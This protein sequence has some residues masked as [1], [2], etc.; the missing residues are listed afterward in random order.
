MVI[1]QYKLDHDGIGAMLA[2]IWESNCQQAVH[3][4]CAYSSFLLMSALADLSKFSVSEPVFTQ[5]ALTLT[6][7]LTLGTMT[8]TTQ[9]RNRCGKLRHSFSMIRQRHYTSTEE[10][11]V[12]EAPYMPE[13][14]WATSH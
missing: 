14:A 9:T 10:H 2:Y 5:Y 8:L 12:R 6:A 13:F 7:C 1:N 11:S 3:V 4:A